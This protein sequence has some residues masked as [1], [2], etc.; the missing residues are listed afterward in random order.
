MEIF[1]PHH[2]P[3][4][5]GL[6]GAVKTIHFWI[7]LILTLCLIR[8]LPDVVMVVIGAWQIGAW[9]RWVYERIIRREE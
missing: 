5:S 6:S 8:I 7:I 3:E 1:D 4:K 2:D 9:A